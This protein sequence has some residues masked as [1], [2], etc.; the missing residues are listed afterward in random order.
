MIDIK[1]QIHRALKPSLKVLMFLV[2][3]SSSIFSHKRDHGYD[4]K[5]CKDLFDAFTNTAKR[6]EYIDSRTKDGE[7]IR[8]DAYSK[9]TLLVHMR[10]ISCAILDSE[11]IY[12]YYYLY[13][14]T[15][16]LKKAGLEP[17]KIFKGIDVTTIK[18]DLESGKLDIDPETKKAL[19]L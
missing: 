17:D 14:L 6:L 3:G 19:G 10:N 4:T 15:D 9:S 12:A 16:E 11:R 8:P 5:I 18:R 1:T 7:K 2:Q 13:V